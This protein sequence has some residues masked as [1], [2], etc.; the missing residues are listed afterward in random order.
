MF[1][2][3]NMLFYKAVYSKPEIKQ[4]IREFAYL[5]FQSLFFFLT[6]KRTR[7]FPIKEWKIINLFT[8]RA[9]H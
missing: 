8:E 3:Y 9:K 6:K 5:L 4:K 7:L 1:Q 2:I